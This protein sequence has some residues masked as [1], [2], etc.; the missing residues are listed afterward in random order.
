MRKS[1][2]FAMVIMGCLFSLPGHSQEKENIGPEEVIRELY[3]LVTIE[4]G[5]TGDWDS[6]RA[7]FI[8]EAVVVLRTSRKAT[9]VFTLEGFVNDFVSFIENYKIIETG[10]N[11]TILNMKSWIYG[12][13]AHVLVL[14]EA[15][16]PNSDFP[17]NKGVDSILLIRK[18]G[19]W[20]I[21][22]ITNEVPTPDRPIPKELIQ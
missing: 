22:A 3:R 20:K 8:E 19:L 14:Y 1:Y 7:L 16:I 10:F 15:E 4:K 5:T 13:M 12:D 2:L 21:A 11:E 17:P 6:V 18:D 9:S